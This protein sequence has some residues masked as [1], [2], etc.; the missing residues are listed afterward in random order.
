[1]KYLDISKNM[2][3][4][5]SRKLTILNIKVMWNSSVFC[6]P[7]EV[8]D[9]LNENRKHIT[10]VNITYNSKVEYYIVFY[11]DTDLVEED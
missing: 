6:T 9:F 4:F 11:F 2:C 5:V 1:L 10:N 8:E 3:I 7:M